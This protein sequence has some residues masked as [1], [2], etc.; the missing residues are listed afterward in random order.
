MSVEDVGAGCRDAGI[1]GLDP[2]SS[3]TGK[4]FL[5]Y[6][7]KKSGSERKA[8]RP[9]FLLPG[10]VPSYG[11]RWFL[12]ISNIVSVAVRTAQSVSYRRNANA[13]SGSTEHSESLSAGETEAVRT[14]S[15]CSATGSD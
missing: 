15:S 1:V 7:A 13:C 4:R 3:G 5:S 10:A 8:R 2:F 9:Q 11:T 14:V 6:V 12:A